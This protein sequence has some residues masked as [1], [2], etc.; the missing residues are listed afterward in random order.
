[1]TREVTVQ[2][3]GMDCGHCAQRL[4]S[5]LERMDGVIRADVDVAGAATVRFDEDRV[6]ETAVAERVRSAGFGV[7]GGEGTP[8]R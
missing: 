1:M 7:A 6:S 3:T 2:V 5:S 8:L 4:G